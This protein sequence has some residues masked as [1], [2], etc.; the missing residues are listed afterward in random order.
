[1]KIVNLRGATDGVEDSGSRKQK[2]TGSAPRRYPENLRHDNASRGRK[3]M[4][5]SVG[6]A[7][8]FGPAECLSASRRRPA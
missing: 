5:V 2:T 4:L 6:S 3:I 7:A 1:M 8:A